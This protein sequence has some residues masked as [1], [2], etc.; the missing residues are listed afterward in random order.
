MTEFIWMGSGH[1]LFEELAQLRHSIF[2]ME[3]GLPRNFGGADDRTCLHLLARRNGKPV[4]CARLA[5]GMGT[6]FIVTTFAVEKEFRGQGI[7]SEMLQEIAEKCRRIG[8]ESLRLTAEL[9]TTAF[10]KRRGMIPTG[11]ECDVA[12][13]TVEIMVAYLD[14]NPYQ[15]S[16]LLPGQDISAALE[17]RREVFGKE[18]GYTN[19]PDELDPIAHT[20][21]M[22]QEGRV[23]ACGRVAPLPDGRYKL[24]KIALSSNLR[25]GGMGRKLVENLEFKAIELGAKEV[26]L[27]SRNPALDFYTHIGY[28][29]YGEEHMEGPEP[30]TDVKKT[31]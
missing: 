7:G 8:C 12:D 3:F 26:F 2:T 11:I 28:T 30:H 29:P 13:Y 23:I 16:W 20:M 27:S 24:G 25:G 6:T 1:P 9:D 22:Y 14:G 4:A 31:L 10:F 18:F 5:R 19:D 17:L 15:V 21:L